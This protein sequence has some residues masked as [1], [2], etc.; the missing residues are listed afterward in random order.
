VVK[1]LFE[2]TTTEDTETAQRNQTF[3]AKLLKLIDL[4]IAGIYPMFKVLLTC[5]AFLTFVLTA[6]GQE[7]QDYQLG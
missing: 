5:L 4:A 1:E 6:A 7:K 2:E 3:R